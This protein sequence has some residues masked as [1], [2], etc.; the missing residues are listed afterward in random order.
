MNQPAA[1]PCY[2]TAVDRY[3]DK[4]PMADMPAAIPPAGVRNYRGPSV[5]QQ[6][7][8]RPEGA[9]VSAETPH[10]IVSGDFAGNVLSCRRPGEVVTRA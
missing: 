5:P 10:A 4:A 1:G 7:A 3:N 8:S 6:A 2:R 9:G